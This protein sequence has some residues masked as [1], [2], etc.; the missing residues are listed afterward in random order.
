MCRPALPPIELGDQCEPA[1]VGGVQV[2]AQL[3]NLV[4]Q[5]LQR[6]RGI[7]LGGDRFHADLLYL[8][9]YTVYRNSQIEQLLTED[10][11][12]PAA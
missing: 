5:V 9:E 3:R 6:G 8:C 12:G 2:S 1:P 11:P 4:G 7:G 10:F